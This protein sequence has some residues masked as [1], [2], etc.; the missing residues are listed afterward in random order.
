MA[1]QI[2]IHDIH[3]KLLIDFY[4]QRLQV[5]RAEMAER[6]RETKEI[7][8]IIQKLKRGDISKETQAAGLAQAA[9]SNYS[10]NWTWIKKVQFAIQ[11]Q[12]KPLTTKEIVE[13]LTEYEPSFIFDR[14]RAVAS[15][16]S[17]LSSKSGTG[18][19]F[20]KV[21]NDIGDS[22][23]TIN[24]NPKQEHL[25]EILDGIIQEPKIKNL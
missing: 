9:P 5:L 23:Y 14:K 22:A 25:F 1:I 6:E 15:I 16:S 12:G 4:I 3:A 2:E 11:Q 21:E 10:E 7:Y 8:T 20:L 18:K 24:I 13:T 19:E 17:I